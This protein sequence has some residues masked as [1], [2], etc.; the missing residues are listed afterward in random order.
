M[1]T[2]LK[3][4]LAVVADP[5][6]QRQLAATKAARI[7]ARA[8]ARLTLF[9]AFM[10]PQATPGVAAHSPQQ[11]IAA[12]VRQRRD[13]LQ[14]LAASLRKLGAAPIRIAV[15]WDYPA[16]EAIVRE[17]LQIKPDLVVAESHRHGR[18]ARWLL[19]NTDWELIR[20]CPAPLWFVRSAALPR[21]LNLLVAVDPRHTHAKPARLDDRL[22]ASAEEL[23]ARLGGEVGIAHAYQPPL[24][25]A[26]GV[27]MEPIRLPRSPQ[28]NRDYIAAVARAVD[29]LAARH[30][31][32]PARRFVRE[33]APSE[34][35]AELTASRKVDVLLLGAVSR[36]VLARPVIGATAE[37]VIDQVEC[38]VFVVKPAGFKTPVGR[39]RPKL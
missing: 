27:L 37:R 8:G 2:R 39:V 10:T 6:A 1:Q 22:L 38:D 36:S 19:A 17:V 34:V 11:V 16:H 15:Q 18:L 14:K 28:R 12:A 31:V 25:A 7:A 24:G 23:V 29:A 32:D 35:I 4:I 30:G 3:H 5:F 20:A 9:N 33:G 13:R 21:K 26:P